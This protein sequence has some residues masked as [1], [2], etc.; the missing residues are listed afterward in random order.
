MRHT[1]L[2]NAQR[3][4][5]RKLSTVRSKDE[6]AFGRWKA[7]F[8]CL[9]TLFT[10]KWTKLPEI[11]RATMILHNMCQ[12]Y[13][14]FFDEEWETRR[15]QHER[16][17]DCRHAELAPRVAQPDPVA[18]EWNNTGTQVLHLCATC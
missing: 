7:R 3:R 10:L 14:E 17:R 8:R 2:N 1:Q 4:F 11:M 5:N 18:E 13:G 15:Q 9:Y 16:E 12:R 6:R